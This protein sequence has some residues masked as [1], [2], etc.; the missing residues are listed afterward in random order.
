MIALAQ[1][2]IGLIH[3]I[4]LMIHPNRLLDAIGLMQPSMDT[5][6]TI[7][8]IALATNSWLSCRQKK[9]ELGE[10]RLC[11]LRVEQK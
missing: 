10:L 5:R 3:A 8:P 9:N 4:G 2:A 7:R 11:A 1:I 6:H